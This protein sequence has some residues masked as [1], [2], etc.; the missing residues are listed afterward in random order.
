MSIVQ[1]GKQ[2]WGADYCVSWFLAPQT[3]VLPRSPGTLGYKNLNNGMCVRLRV[4]VFVCVHIL[5]IHLSAVKCQTT[6]WMRVC[7]VCPSPQTSFWQ[8]ERSIYWQENQKKQN[9]KSESACHG[10]E[11]GCQRPT[12][13]R[14]KM[15]TNVSNEQEQTN[16]ETEQRCWSSRRSPVN[17]VN[18]ARGRLQKSRTRVK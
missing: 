3:S 10:E 12:S 5:P 11:L 17:T 4:S 8:S 16:C 1:F 9:K 15:K 18:W 7:C 6:R 2:W 13:S 14:K